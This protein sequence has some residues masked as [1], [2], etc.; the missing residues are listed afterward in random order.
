MIQRQQSLW[1]LLTAICAFLTFKLPFFAGGRANTTTTVGGAVYIDAGSNFFLLVLTGI[2]ML[3]AV[4]AIFL[5]KDR[6]LQLKFC[7][8]GLVLSIITIVFYFVQIKALPGAIALSAIF[9]FLMPVGYI[10]AARGIWK[11][12][13]LVKSL[14]KLR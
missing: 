3:I 14:D 9:A 8:S 11:D 13:K 12:E 6:K 2:S 7:L 10:M 5:F 1:L 4:I